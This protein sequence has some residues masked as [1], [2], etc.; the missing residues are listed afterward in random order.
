MTTKLYEFHNGKSKRFKKETLFTRSMKCTWS[1][2][3]REENFIQMR[4]DSLKMHQKSLQQHLASCKDDLA[5][6][7]DQQIVEQF[8]NVKSYSKFLPIYVVR[9]QNQSDLVDDLSRSFE[10]KRGQNG[11]NFAEIDCC[12]IDSLSDLIR[13]LSSELFANKKVECRF[14]DQFEKHMENKLPNDRVIILLKNF[15]QMN[16]R[17][18]NDFLALCTDS[19]VMPRKLSIVLPLVCLDLESVE[20]HFA[21]RI[22]NRLHLKIF[23]SSNPRYFLDDLLEKLTIDENFL[24]NFD[25]ETLTYLQKIWTFNQCNI[26]RFGSALNLLMIDH[27]LDNSLSYFCSSKNELGEFFKKVPKISN[28]LVESPTKRQKMMVKN[29]GV[30]NPAL[31]NLQADLEDFY[32]FKSSQ[33]ILIDIGEILLKFCKDET[34]KSINIPAYRLKDLNDYNGIMDCL[35]QSSGE[36]LLKLFESISIL[37]NQSSCPLFDQLGNFISA[38]QEKL[39]QTITL[40]RSL[41]FSPEKSIIT[42]PKQKFR[43]VSDLKK[44]LEVKIRQN[45][46]SGISGNNYESIKRQIVG[47]FWQKFTLISQFPDRSPLKTSFYTNAELYNVISSQFFEPNSRKA[48][49]E[50]LALLNEAKIHVDDCLVF[51]K[52]ISLNQSIFV[53]M[54]FKETLLKRGLQ[55][56][57]VVD[58]LMARF[59]RVLAQFE[60]IGLVKLKLKCKSMK[61]LVFH[62]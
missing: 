26:D 48:L 10:R 7:L 55:R 51:E 27:F 20:V 8:K 57:E 6:S 24:L 33:K 14:F 21:S 11:L 47:D 13:N 1:A 35:N 49:K 44:T 40:N 45:R 4:I 2:L 41:K 46:Q 18:F 5:T 25:P 58:K 53:K 52:F 32:N 12:Q 39:D 37:S 59:Y 31:Y 30:E 62:F 43:N 50:A 36:E 38:A 34:G 60:Y 42:T 3:S 15:N 29:V 22:R 9:L 19:H 54:W 28:N 23:D 61:K 56:K 17:I 16:C